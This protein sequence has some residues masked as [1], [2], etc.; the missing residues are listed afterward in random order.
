M[1]TQVICFNKTPSLIPTGS[2]VVCRR[3]ASYVER[4][5]DGYV[6]PELIFLIGTA[7]ISRKSAMD[8]ERVIQVTARAAQIEGLCIPTMPLPFV[9]LQLF[10]LAHGTGE[11]GCL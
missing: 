11:S 4:R 8:V 6:E 1:C 10:D 5:S 2:L 3:P 9:P 7:H